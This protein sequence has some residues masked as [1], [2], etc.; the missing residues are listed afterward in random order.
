MKKGI[1]TLAVFTATCVAIATY[2]S[3]MLSKIAFAE[4]TQA[5]EQPNDEAAIREMNAAVEAAWNKHDAPT[6]DQG[7]VEDCDFINVFGEWIFTRDKLV[8][9][10]TALF[11]G[12][13]RESYKRF[14]VEKIRFVR[15]D[16]AIAH[17]RGRNTDRDGKLLEADKGTIATLIMVKEGGKWRIVAGQNTE[18]RP[19]PEAFKPVGKPAP[20][21]H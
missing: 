18:V 19:L 1:V 2:S 15:Q 12:P 14:T 9:I 16:V 21:H 5:K 10:H 7:W 3:R 17:V 6:L 8:K 20:N 13:F 4:S 11:A